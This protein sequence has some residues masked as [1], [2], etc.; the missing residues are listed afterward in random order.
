MQYLWW[1][2]IDNETLDPLSHWVQH[3]LALKPCLAPEDFHT[4]QDKWLPNN[5]RLS[6][7]RPREGIL[8]YLN[9]LRPSIPVYREDVQAAMDFSLLTSRLKER[10]KGHQFENIKTLF[11]IIEEIAVYITSLL[12]CQ[13]FSG[14]EIKE[15]LIDRD[16]VIRGEFQPLKYF[17]DFF[18]R[19]LTSGCFQPSIRRT[20]W[21]SDQIC[22]TQIWN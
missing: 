6:R 3:S 8:T 12:C 18:C 2:C 20:R 7:H 19:T 1:W 16:Y 15:K 13:T 5:H 9:T 22:L 11:R 10:G 4:N 14:A 17:Y 21:S